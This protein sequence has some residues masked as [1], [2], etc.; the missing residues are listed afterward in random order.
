MFS[1]AKCLGIWAAR[2]PD[3]ARGDLYPECNSGR[4]T[5]LAAATSQGQSMHQFRHAKIQE[6]PD[7]KS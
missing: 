2:N 3:A 1:P 7:K 4:T 5:Q 6:N